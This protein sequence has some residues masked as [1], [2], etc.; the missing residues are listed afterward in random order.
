MTLYKVSGLVA[1]IAGW[2]PGFTSVTGETMLFKWKKSTTHL[3]RRHTRDTAE[4]IQKIMYLEEETLRLAKDT[5][6][7][8]HII[9]QLKTL[10]WMSS[11][12]APTTLARQL[13]SKDNVV[14]EADGP[15]LMV[16]GC[17][18]ETG[19]SLCPPHYTTSTRRSVNGYQMTPQQIT[20]DTRSQLQK[21]S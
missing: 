4:D 12:S 14:A 21:R 8:C 3:Y 13:L 15:I 7:L 2:D 18:I 17:N 11:E 16:W 5:K 19:G 9:T 10:F 6:M 1:P 20:L